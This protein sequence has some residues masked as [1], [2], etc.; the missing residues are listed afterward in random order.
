MRT[1]RHCFGHAITEPCML[2]PLGVNAYRIHVCDR[3][4]RLNCRRR[5]TFACYDNI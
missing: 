4:V 5:Q 1:L 3:P 2:V